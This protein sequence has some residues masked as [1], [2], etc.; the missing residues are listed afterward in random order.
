LLPKDAIGII[1][2]ND[3]MPSNA[4]GT[5]PYHPNSDLFY[6]SGIEQEESIM[7]LNPGAQNARDRA[8]L[9]I[10]RPDELLKIWEGYKLDKKDARTL[11]GISRIHWLDEFWSVF[12]TLAR[13]SKTFFLNDNEHQRA[14]NP[15]ETRDQRLKKEIRKRYPK[16][17]H[18]RLAPLLHE[19]RFVKNTQE[20]EL[21][22]QAVQVTAEGYRKVLGLVKPGVMEYEIEAEWARTFISN[23]C[24][25]AYG[26]I[27]AAGKNA[28][29]LHYLQNDQI[30][31]KGEL[32]LMDVG[33]SYAN[34]NADLTR[35]IPVSGKFNRRQRAIYNAV[36]RVLK[37]SIENASVG[38]SLK[39]WTRE[40]QDLMN[41]EL[42]S[43]K[44]LSL[45]DI[46]N[47]DPK[48]P[49]CR[50]Y[51][52]HGLGHSLGLDVHDVSNG[53]YILRENS[54]FTI[55]PGIYIPQEKIGIRLEE[56]IVITPKGPLIL[57]KNAPIEPDEI[58]AIMNSKS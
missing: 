23:R 27:I 43:L 30:C 57:T 22:Q 50:K 16:R 44:L 55:E 17:Q 47:Q 49:A 45:R 37:A 53:Q 32:L 25:F 42:V 18:G 26:P 19:L 4:D 11:S 39:Q 31:K 46:K 33:A 1:N 14:D 12:S 52:M 3:L 15:V 51:F 28:C 9:F 58:E 13:G 20:I 29:V 7:V 34:Y 38:K 2:A 24:K 36:L 41:E 10:R 40:A 48:N 5:L 35:T 21:I 8:V 6:L 56:N 54:V